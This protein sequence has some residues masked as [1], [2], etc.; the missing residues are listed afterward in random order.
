MNQIFVNLETLPDIHGARQMYQLPADLQAKDVAK[1]LFHQH[2]STLGRD[3][4]FL[5]PWQAR[6]AVVCVIAISG[7]DVELIQLDMEQSDELQMLQR[8]N[9]IQ[10]A[11]TDAFCW[12]QGREL[13]ALLHMRAMIHQTGY[14][15]APLQP[16]DQCLQIPPG[17]YALE[18]IAAR[19]GQQAVAMAGDELSWK[20]YR[21]QGIALLEKRCRTNVIA[22]TLLGLHH[23]L[24]SGKIERRRFDQLATACGE[25]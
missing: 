4:L 9:D 1:V 14:D 25:L 16:V 6:I 10:H 17:S 15:A 3:Q 18:A 12:D 22:T 19:F 13:N 5:Q 23:L 7:A 21:Q 20:L 11:S 8:L 24:T 2:V